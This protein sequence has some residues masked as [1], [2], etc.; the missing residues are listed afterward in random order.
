MTQIAEA[1]GHATLATHGKRQ[2]ALSMYA[3]GKAFV[4]AAILVGRQTQSEPTDYVVLHL[5]CQ[6]IEIT[7]KGLLLLRD[8]NHFIGQLRTPL[9]HNLL[10][11]ANEVSLAYGINP[12]RHTVEQ[13]LRVLNELYSRHLLR[14]GS[15]YD[16]LVDPRTIDRKRVLRRIGA[17]IRLAERELKREQVII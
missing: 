4:G 10:E 9:G 3:K 5:L 12:P 7:L 14:Y 11:V 13:D 1:E 16:I 17:A 8:Y 2:A 6:G 15:G